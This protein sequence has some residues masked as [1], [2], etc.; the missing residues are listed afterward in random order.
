M[1]FKMASP[2]NDGRT[3][4]G[5][6]TTLFASSICSMSYI[7]NMKKYL[8]LKQSMLGIRTILLF[9]VQTPSLGRTQWIVAVPCD[10]GE[11]P[12]DMD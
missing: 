1:A 11:A 3:E 2:K 8:D 5:L 9:I 6:I 7:V 4:N 12:C 10:L